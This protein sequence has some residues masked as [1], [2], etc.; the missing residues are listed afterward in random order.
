MWQYCFRE[1]YDR[2]FDGFNDY[3]G[4]SWDS[5]VSI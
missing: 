2:V 3:N 1:E 5:S 4:F